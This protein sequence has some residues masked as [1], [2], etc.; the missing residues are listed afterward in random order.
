MGVGSVN[1]HDMS[2]SCK[3]PG[4][5]TR[6]CCILTVEA[7]IA[8][9]GQRMDLRSH[10]LMNQNGQDGEIDHLNVVLEVILF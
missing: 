3:H 5:A 2:V 4:I 8:L 7:E 1:Q 9:S 10:D 6:D